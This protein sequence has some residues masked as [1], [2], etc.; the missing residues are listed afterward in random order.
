MIMLV[1]PS[2]E[3]PEL[4]PV[5]EDEPKMVSCLDVGKVL[6]EVD[7]VEVDVVE[8]V[9]VIAEAGGVDEPEGTVALKSDN[10]L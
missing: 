1:F 4:L 3:S 2:S 10:S 7:A 8:E 9:D 6:V 5:V